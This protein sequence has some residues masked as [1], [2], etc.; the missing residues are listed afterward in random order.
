MGRDLQWKLLCFDPL[1]IMYTFIYMIDTN[2]KLQSQQSDS[3][4]GVCSKT[5]G[6]VTSME[7]DNEIQAQKA[8]CIYSKQG[9]CLQL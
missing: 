5:L 2:S 3:Q 9:C 6:K 4:T 7:F 1:V 8:A